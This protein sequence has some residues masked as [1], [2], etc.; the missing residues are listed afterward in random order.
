MSLFS[1]AFKG[2]NRSISYIKGNKIDRKF[3]VPRIWSNQELEKFAHL[4]HGNIANVSGWKDEDKEGSLYSDYFLN[5]DHYTITNYDQDKERGYQGSCDEIVIDLEKSLSP[6]HHGKYNVVF[7]HT[8]LEHI[9]NI[10]IAFKNLCI[11]SN[12]VVIVVV[13]FIQQLHGLNDNVFDFWRFTP[14]SLK[15]LF[16][17]NG[18]KLRY[19]SSNGD[20]SN[21]SIYL[22]AI[23]YRGDNWDNQIPFQFNTKIDNNRHLTPTNAI[24]CN[25]IK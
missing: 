17:K 16:E 3:R 12:E 22:F 18:L 21:S 10:D 24:G 7:C 25:I 13:P 5:A 8:V 14:Y 1:E 9:F 19:C 2:I 6:A 4:F 20:N 23:G 11:L 15:F